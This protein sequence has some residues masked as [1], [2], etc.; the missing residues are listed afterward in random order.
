M[1][2]E[3]SKKLKHCKDWAPTQ[4][5]LRPGVVRSSSDGFLRLEAF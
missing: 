3:T 2:K 5:P 4:P 1:H